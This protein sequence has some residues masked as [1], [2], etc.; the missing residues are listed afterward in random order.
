M[1]LP[2]LDAAPDAT[3]I[4]SQGIAPLLTLSGRS[5]LLPYRRGR[6]GFREAVRTLRRARHAYGVLLTP[7]F[8]SA[9]MM[10][11][12]AVDAIRGAGTDR[13]GLL[14]DEAVPVDRVTGRP[15]PLVYYELVTR[16]TLAE[17][18]VPALHVPGAARDAWWQLLGIG[19][20][21]VIGVFPGG[22]APSRRWEPARFAEV[23]TGL[24]T[25]MPVVVFGG[26]AEAGITAG[27]AGERGID[28][29]GRTDLPMLAAALAECDILITND[30]GPLHLAAAVGT[31]TLSL[32]GAGDPAETAVRGTGHALLR[33]PE[34]PCVPCVR[35]ECP[36]R[37]EG[38]VLPEARQEC[39]QLIATPDVLSAARRMLA[40]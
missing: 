16:E 39:L 20:Q 9:F 26:P 30:S 6:R 15:R 23:V 2:A 27:I 7:S 4:V 34:L 8:S 31:R 35:N 37:G 13:R 28:M 1:S 17:P 22:N 38:F 33:H 32:W 36:R 25:D 24:A 12:G 14:L 40:Q 29:G 3:I 18:P 11:V 19:R 5:R 21:P 10:R